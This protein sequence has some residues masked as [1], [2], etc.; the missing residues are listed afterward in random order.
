MYSLARVTCPLLRGF[1]TRRLF[2]SSSSVNMTKTL[3]ELTFVNGV[4]RNLPIDEDPSERPHT[5]RNACFSLVKPTPLPNPRLVCYSL[6]ALKL[7]DLDES[8]INEH[9]VKCFTGNE[10]ISGSE[11]FSHCYCG[12]QFGEVNYLFFNSL[13]CNILLSHDRH[14]CWTT[15]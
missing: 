6:S 3:D 14:F 15:R 9:F 11:T 8:S 13:F 1:S 12:H 4:L 7:I 10:I 2:S 5:V